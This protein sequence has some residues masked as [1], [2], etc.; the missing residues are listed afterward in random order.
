MTELDQALHAFVQDETKQ[1]LYYQAVRETV[2]Y[3][4]TANAEAQ[5]TDG[6]ASFTPLVLENDGKTYLML[7]D[8]EE[9]L[10]AWSK[11]ECDYVMITGHGIAKLTPPALHWAINI[12]SA[13]AK[14]F[15]PEEIV[16]L[17]D[18]ETGAVY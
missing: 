13:Y 4:P 18:V 12:G 2:F 9:K 7:F 15:V 16:W 3:L 14:E 11:E 8:T 5:S 1:D 6:E 17:R 10:F